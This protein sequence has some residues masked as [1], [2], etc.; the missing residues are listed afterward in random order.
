M[1]TAVDSSVLLAIFNAEPSSER[2]MEAL[3][4]ARHEGRLVICGIVY[5]EIASGFVDQSS[6][7]QNLEILGISLLEMNSE[8]AWEAG[9]VFRLYRNKGG[10]REHLIP[11][12]LIAAHAQIQANRLAA[13]DRGYLRQW[14]KDLT[15]LNYDY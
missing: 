2:W 6:L 7:N 13:I 12:F 15:L 10:P 11:D 3:I 5:A 4:K 9:K 14:F 1:I 8:S